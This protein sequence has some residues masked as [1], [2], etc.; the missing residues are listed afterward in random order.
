MFSPEAKIGDLSGAMRQ[1]LQLA[2]E[3]GSVALPSDGCPVRG[4]LSRAIQVGKFPGSTDYGSRGAG[5]EVEPPEIAV[6]IK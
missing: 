2:R 1:L 5:K 4:P 3:D 6:K